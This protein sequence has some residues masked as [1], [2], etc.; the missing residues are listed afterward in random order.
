[1]ALTSTE[2]PGQNTFR[3]RS[4][5]VRNGPPPHL[6]LV[7]AVGIAE[8]PLERPL[9]PRDRDDQIQRGDDG[10]REAIAGHVCRA[11]YDQHPAEVKRMP[12]E[13]V[14]SPDL[15][16]TTPCQAAPADTGQ[17]EC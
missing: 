9:F 4:E 16:R 8:R 14:R 2:T 13:P 15:Q 17:L 10:E 5:H 3:T 6:A 12:D 1:M 11:E 7:P